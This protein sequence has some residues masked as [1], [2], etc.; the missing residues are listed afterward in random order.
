MQIITITDNNID[1]FAR[2]AAT[3]PVLV[4]YHSPNCGHCLAMEDEWQELGRSGLVVDNNVAIVDIDVSIADKLNHPSA[5]NALSVG[6]PSIYFLKGSK[7]VEYKGDRNSKKM[8]DFV[9]SNTHIKGGKKQPENANNTGKLMDSI[10]EKL[11]KIGDNYKRSC[12]TGRPKLKYVATPGKILRK[13]TR[14]KRTRRKHTRRKS[15]Q[16]HMHH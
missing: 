10:D 4:R 12:H 9:N 14:R 5:K 3:R 6:V 11:R 7:M 15:L 8:A 1:E 16:Q 2:I 13:R